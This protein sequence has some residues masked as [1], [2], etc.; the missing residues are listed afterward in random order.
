[1]E[2]EQLTTLLKHVLKQKEISLRQLGRDIGIDASTLSRI[3]NNK[4]RPNITQL[5]KMAIGLGLSLEELLIAAGYRLSGHAYP[6]NTIGE[7]MI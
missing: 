6:E 3:L 2:E 5:E 7:K 1:M 4:Q